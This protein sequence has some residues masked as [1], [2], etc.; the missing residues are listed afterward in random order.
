MNVSDIIMVTVH[1]EQDPCLLN[2]IAH[3]YRYFIEQSRVWPQL[4]HGK[5]FV[6]CCAAHTVSSWSR[7]H[8]LD[9]EWMLRSK[10]TLI[11]CM[12]S[13]CEMLS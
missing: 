9:L 3:H 4:F 7:V 2:R 13:V 12:D 1:C 6:G 5:F 8:V 11:L 10:C